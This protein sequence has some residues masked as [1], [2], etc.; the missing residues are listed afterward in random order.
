MR[1][2][3]TMLHITA[4]LVL[5]IGIPI[6]A[7]QKKTAARTEAPAAQT[8]QQAQDVHPEIDPSNSCRDCHEEVTPEVH[9]EWFAS[10]HG[11]NGVLCVVC[12]GGLDNFVKAPRTD[13]CEGCHA[14]QTQT[15]DSEFMKSKTCFTCH[16][17]HRLLPHA[18]KP[19]PDPGVAD[20]K[21]GGVQ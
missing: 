20:R 12:H 14:A 21:T 11:V 10:A 1:C 9:A 17:P 16:P 2:Q 3:R 13:R 19:R 4:A 8:A 6:A 5:L 7:A 18:E 15:M